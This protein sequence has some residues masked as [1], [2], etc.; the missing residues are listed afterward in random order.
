MQT[1][2][3][4]LLFSVTSLLWTPVSDKTVVTWKDR[5]ASCLHGV[6]TS[7][8]VMISSGLFLGIMSV[9][10]I[11]LWILLTLAVTTLKIIWKIPRRDQLG[12][13][14]LASFSFPAVLFFF[15]WIAPEPGHWIAGGWDPGIY[16]NQG[17]AMSRTGSL[18]PD[19]QWFHESIPEEH[20][21]SFLR[22]FKNRHERF[23][24]VVIKD[25]RISYEF[26]RLFPAAIGI[27]A[28]LGGVEL[29]SRTNYWIGL[30]CLATAAGWGAMI[31][32]KAML[33]FPV[34]LA[35]QPI[36]TYHTHLPVT[37]MLELGLVLWAGMIF[38][39]FRTSSGDV[40]RI[41][42]ALFCAILNRFS[43][44]PFSGLF[45]LTACVLLR[46]IDLCAIKRIQIL[47]AYLLSTLMGLAISFVISPVSIHGWSITPVLIQVFVWSTL[48][49]TILLFLPLP[50]TFKPKFQVFVDRAITFALPFM[51]LSLLAFFWF[52]GQQPHQYPYLQRLLPFIG[53]GWAVL[54]L[55]ACLSTGILRQFSPGA[56]MFTLF[57]LSVSLLMMYDPQ[58]TE[59]YPWALRRY[60]SFNLPMI[61]LMLLLLVEALSRINAPKFIRSGLVPL[62][63]LTA[64]LFSGKTFLEGLRLRDYRGLEPILASVSEHLPDDAIV[65][66]DDPRWGTPL[67]LIYGKKIL[68][69][70][71]LWQREDPKEFEE[72]LGMLSEL[73]KV[74][75]LTSLES[76]MSIYPEIPSDISVERVISLDPITVST[77]SQHPR[78]ARFILQPMTRVFTI[79]KLST[80]GETGREIPPP[81]SPQIPGL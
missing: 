1:L 74:Y 2:T 75:F 58:I 47:T 51:I 18:Y 26:S 80:H 56:K 36:F 41:A 24:G 31:S 64:F 67:H 35:V 81:T 48:L 12:L 17:V 20:Q 6:W 37:E 39:Q 7:F 29:A 57:I 30:L 22:I 71:G 60:L 25:S 15:T 21:R 53:I 68:C 49:G 32:V 70:R 79:H 62:L 55:P 61:L 10:S 4:I 16:M 14:H 66:S 43:M 77:I 8:L 44:V 63:L 45:F 78:A 19:D 11:P 34:L 69:G 54:F 5:L 50:K 40:V 76:E 28:E 23:P 59:W 3:A 46:S 73:P 38:F 65:I 13:E 52:R 27:F 33:L 72:I 9:F 42:F